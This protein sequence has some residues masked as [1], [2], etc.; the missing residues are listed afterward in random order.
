[1]VLRDSFRKSQQPR[2]YYHT[3]MILSRDHILTTHVSSLPRN[4]TGWIGAECVM[5]AVLRTD[6][7][8]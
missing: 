2:L 3:H 6:L 1:M 4:E 5:N 7:S 8:M